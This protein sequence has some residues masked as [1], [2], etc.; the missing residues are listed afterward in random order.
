MR[1]WTAI[2][3][4]YLPLSTLKQDILDGTE[5]GKKVR[6]ERTTRPELHK[7]FKFGG[8][9]IEALVVEDREFMDG[10]IEE[11]VLDY[12]AQDDNGTVYYLGEDVDDYK[13]GK[14]V[15]HEGSW[16]TGKD[17]PVPGVFF[18]AHAKVGMKWRSKDVSKSISERNEIIAMGETVIVPAG[19]F[20]DCVKVREL[21]GDGATEYKYFCKG[22]GVVR[23]IPA[24][25]DEGL[26]SHATR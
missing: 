13:D 10:Q 14:I 19:T 6:I 22:I 1:Q 16:L 21:I 11:D 4:P 12:F 8:M 17:T 20:K 15:G 23:E 5:G 18:P 7:T 9:E 24:D 3:N 25:G 2:D 26:I